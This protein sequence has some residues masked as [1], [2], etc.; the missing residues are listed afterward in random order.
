MD[1]RHLRQFV[2]LAETLN[3]RKAA[4]K[5]HM[6]Q[7]PLSVSIR[8]LETELGVDLF[9]R[10]KDGVQLTKNGEAALEQAKR[11]LFFAD[12]F[13]HT[14]RAT[15]N[16]ERGVLRI[17]FVGSSTRSILPAILSMF[18]QYYPGVQL[19]LR[20]SRSTQIVEA[21]EDGTLDIGIVR[22]PVPASGYLKM[23]T[24]QTERLTLAI[25]HNHRFA[26][27]SA[28]RMADLIDEDFIFYT[29][30]APGLRMAALH[31]CEAH[32]FT[33]RI[34]QEAVQVATVMS[35]VDAGLGIALLPSAN[36]GIPSDR[37]ICKAVVDFPDS[38]SIGISVAW[39]QENETA[40]IRNFYRLA[41]EVFPEG[42]KLA[43]LK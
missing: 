15:S 32:G 28:I 43:P 36:S 13:V 34:A 11:A 25:P 16:G 9:Q 14:A 20:E 17:G 37:M 1:F 39:C 18:R 10:G 41:K 40:T 22:I 33:P 31:A 2:T 29:E 8:K 23:Q 38:A 7:P 6:S 19:V 30:D 42:E 4:E 26:A 24:L 21:L 5:L 3:F 12:E 27:R 35:L